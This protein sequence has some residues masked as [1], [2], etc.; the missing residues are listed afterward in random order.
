V[1]HLRAHESLDDVAG[2][3]RPARPRTDAEPFARD[4]VDDF[5]FDAR[6]LAR[7]AVVGADES[8]DERARRSIVE[9]L[10]ACRLLER[11]AFITAT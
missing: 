6:R 10:R 1:E 2:G 7:D 3:D 9:L 4:H 11:P 8:G 5:A